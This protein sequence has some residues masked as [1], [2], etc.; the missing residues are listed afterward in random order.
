M[1]RSL[2][3]KPFSSKIFSRKL[4]AIKKANKLRELYHGHIHL[5]V[6]KKKEG[7]QIYQFAWKYEKIKK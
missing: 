5:R 1:K 2:K 7:Y 6:I 3:G 4:D